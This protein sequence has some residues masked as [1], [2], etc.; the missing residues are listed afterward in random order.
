MYWESRPCFYYS[1][2]LAGR[3]QLLC[4]LPRVTLAGDT[5]RVHKGYV[6]YA[7]IL[8]CPSFT[9]APLI[10]TYIIL[11]M[12][13]PVRSCLNWV[14]G[15]WLVPD[16]AWKHRCWRLGWAGQWYSHKVLHWV[17]KP[18][19]LSQSL[20]P[21]CL[22]HGLLGMMSLWPPSFRA[23]HV[24]MAPLSPDL[25]LGRDTHPLPHCF[26]SEQHLALI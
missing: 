23:L 5:L 26:S 18:I 15:R 14:P 13:L 12:L 9:P 1:F 17:P 4:L 25:S 20:S 6:G 7:L 21:M 19:L 8:N 11:V 22:H 16:I 24:P 3:G 2:K 10:L